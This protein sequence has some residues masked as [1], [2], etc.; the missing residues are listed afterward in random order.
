[1]AEKLGR[2]WASIELVEEYVKASMFRFEKRAMDALLT[3]NHRQPPTGQL[4]ELPQLVRG[5]I[6]F[7]VV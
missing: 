5:N 7:G 1:V 2:R 4:A 3:T 6:F